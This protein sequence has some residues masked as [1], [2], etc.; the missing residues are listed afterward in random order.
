MWSFS[1]RRTHHQFIRGIV[2]LCRHRSSTEVF[3]YVTSA[4][5][6]LP[7]SPVEGAG[8]SPI[9][10]SKF[11]VIPCDGVDQPDSA[12]LNR[13]VITSTARVLKQVSTMPSLVVVGDQ[14]DCVTDQGV[15]SSIDRKTSDVIWTQR[16]PGH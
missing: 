2:I 16:I 15:A 9:V 1:A 14:S 10:A 6:V 5:T 8:R 13:N 3:C 11:L 12:S 4:S 7:A